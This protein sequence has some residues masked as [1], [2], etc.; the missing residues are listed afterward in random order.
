MNTL[1]GPDAGHRKPEFLKQY[2]GYC[3]AIEINV[4]LHGSGASE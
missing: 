2:R 1:P 4:E 3:Q